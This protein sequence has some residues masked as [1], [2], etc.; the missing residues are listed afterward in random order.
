M[1]RAV[2]IASLP[3]APGQ[4]DP[5]REDGKRQIALTFESV[6]TGRQR[7]TMQARAA[8]LQYCDIKAA[9][10]LTMLA[11]YE[12]VARE[13]E[14][15]A[16]PPDLQ[17]LVPVANDRS[18]GAARLSART[19]RRWA[20]E[21]KK[22]GTAGVAPQRSRER[23]PAPVWMDAF[24]RYY[25][26]PMKPSIADCLR[27]WQEDAPTAQLPSYSAV[28]TALE[29]L[30]HHERARG[31]EGRLALKARSAFTKRDTSDLLPGSVYAA[32]GTT[33][34]REVEHPI[35]GRPFK[36]ELTTVIDAH[37]RRVV[38]WSAGLAE[39]WQA[40][41]EALRH[42]CAA[43]IPAIF[44]SDR[45]SGY[46]N[47]KMD[48]EI[49]GFLAR[50]GVTPMRALPYHSWAKG[51]V[52]SFQKQ[53]ITLAKRAPT[54]TGRDMDKEARLLAFK[55]TRREVALFGQSRLLI[56]WADF[57]GEVG[58]FIEKYNNRP[59]RGLPRIRDAQNGVKRNLTPNEM[60][61]KAVAERGFE[62]IVPAE[63]EM[64]DLFRPYEI[65][66]ARRCCVQLG[67]NSYF[68]MALDPFHEKEV[69]VGYDMQ[70]ATR[71]WVREIDRTAEGRIPGRLI[72]VASFEGNSSRY[73]PVSM[74]QRAMEQRAKGR[75]RR[76]QAHLAVVQEELR[77]GVIDAF[78]QNVNAPHV[79]IPSLKFDAPRDAALTPLPP[80]GEDADSVARSV[81]SEEVTSFAPA[82]ESA[83]ED[84]R[85]HFTDDA[86]FAHW[87]T[88]HADQATETDRAYA[89]ELLSDR[90][91]REMLRMR[92]V[93][94]EALRAIAVEHP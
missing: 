1:A 56:S 22:A 53:W 45:G 60:W 19:L 29:K 84:E 59:H 91:S 58:D 80:Q 74:E 75:E 42:A 13:A 5:S 32:D 43:C 16:L 11:A 18:G 69:M 67:T 55:T 34:D 3:L 78:A 82:A 14:A 77:P 4:P 12:T 93:D 73:V 66:M 44:Y 20:T 57:L 94:C 51:N 17:A 36:P 89:R 88:R 27:Q 63:E 24:L 64:H 10:G 49:T 41:I 28:R 61:A 7:Q 65:R 87:L 26:R 39:G 8:L 68:D 79:E 33:W 71:V 6:L 30:S 62:P 31:R 2:Q 52:E 50:L 46:I 72:C 81:V 40:T 76:L 38:G 25:A 90:T 35:H 92:G 54:Y 85:P 86:G 48:G 70:D 37:T 83:R 9:Q 21:R 23:E 47:E 15:C